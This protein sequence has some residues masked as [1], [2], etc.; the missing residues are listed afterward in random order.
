MA[1]PVV[2]APAK[3][4]L[5]REA[6]PLVFRIEERLTTAGIVAPRV[7]FASR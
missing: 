5:G 7:V 4:N 6:N 2:F 3:N 1:K